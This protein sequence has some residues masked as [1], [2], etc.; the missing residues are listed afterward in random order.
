MTRYS[1][2]KLVSHKENVVCMDVG[3]CADVDVDEF[4]AQVEVAEGYMV[5][6]L[7]LN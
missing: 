6:L 4:K 7:N 2:P 3:V 5:L 1:R